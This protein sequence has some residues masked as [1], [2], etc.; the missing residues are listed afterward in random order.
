MHVLRNRYTCNEQDAKNQQTKLLVHK[1]DW[2]R[3][4]PKAAAPGVCLW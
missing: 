4:I 1:I 2:M 3:A